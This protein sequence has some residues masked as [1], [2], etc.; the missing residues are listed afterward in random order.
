MRQLILDY[1]ELE[2][3]QILNKKK[4][5]RIKMKTTKTAIGLSVNPEEIMKRSEQAEK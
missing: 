2:I 3:K 5:N 4:H 1:T